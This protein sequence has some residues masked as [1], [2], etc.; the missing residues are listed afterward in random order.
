MAEEKEPGAIG[1][2]V[3][4]VTAPVKLGLKILWAIAIF[5]I[6][7]ILGLFVFVGAFVGNFLGTNSQP[8]GQSTVATNPTGGGGTGGTGSTGQTGTTASGSL[9][10]RIIALARAELGNCE[11]PPGGNWNT[12]ARI[13]DYKR[14]SGN[15]EPWCASFATYVLENAGVPIGHIAGARAVGNYFQNNSGRGFQ[16]INKNSGSPQPGDIFVQKRDCAR[17]PGA[18]GHIGIVVSVNPSNGTFETVEG[19]VGDCVSRR[20]QR[21]SNAALIGFG[22]YNGR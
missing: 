8:A 11:D 18:C 12:S 9:A 7:L 6:L 20:T 13:R 4:V 21:I 15:H 22:R 19:N 2:T 14:G 17:G 1:K 3:K 10:D 16:W 5:L